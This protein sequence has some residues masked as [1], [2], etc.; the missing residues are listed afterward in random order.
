MIA[1]MTMTDLRR[2]EA[3]CTTAR[4]MLDAADVVGLCEWVKR[5]LAES[6]ATCRECGARAK[7]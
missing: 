7:R 6:T 2:V 5:L 3:R 1:P 4:V